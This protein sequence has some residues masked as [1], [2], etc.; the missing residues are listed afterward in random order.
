MKLLGKA[1]PDSL[2][3][4]ADALAARPDAVEE[5]IKILQKLVS[6]Q[7]TSKAAGLPT[8]QRKLGQAMVA[9]SQPA[10]GAVHLGKACLALGQ[11][12]DPA[13]GAVWRE[14]VRALLAAD[15]PGVVG[16]I[17]AQGDKAL[18]AQGM[19]WLGEHLTELDRR[20][21][22]AAILLLAAEAQKG[23]AG[24]LS[25]EQ[26]LQLSDARQQALAKQQADDI[27]RVAQAVGKLVGND[28]LARKKAQADLQAMGDRAVRPLLGE[29]LKV[30]RTEPLNVPLEK[31]IV[32]I[33]R[34]SAPKLT[35]YDL[36]AG[37]EDRV[38]LV[39]KWLAD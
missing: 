27:Q 11:A 14:W 24:R 37:R 5:R 3:R 9:A 17:A 32:A 10:E 28:E 25:E 30:L 6:L 2:A 23:L 39:E 29:L 15:D 8:A 36:A 12:K 13:A 22:Y 7:E 19:A 20:K 21:S 18:A 4:T 35:G 34:E 38:K 16:A 31:A 1:D 26:A 33:V